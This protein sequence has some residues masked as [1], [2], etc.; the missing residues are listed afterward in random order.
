MVG[1]A[2]FSTLAFAMTQASAHKILEWASRQS[3]S[4]EQAA[5]IRSQRSASWIAV[6]MIVYILLS[7]TPAVCWRVQSGSWLTG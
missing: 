5:A 7:A 2:F 3:P 1:I 4:L 6:C